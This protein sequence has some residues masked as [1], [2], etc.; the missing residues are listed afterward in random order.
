MDSQELEHLPGLTAQE[1]QINLKKFGYNDL[2]A[3]KKRSVFFLWINVLKEPMFLL[4][5]AS[6][7]IYW[8]IGDIL[9]ASVLFGSIFFI[10]GLTFYQENKTEKTLLALKELSSPKATVIR[11]HTIV[12]IPSREV[13]VGDIIVLKEGDRV[14]ADAQFISGTNITVDESLL[15][16]ES[17]PVNKEKDSSFYSG[18]LVVRGQGI[19]KVTNI[20]TESKIGKIG[21]S[22]QKIKIQKTTL[23]KN[24]GVLVKYLSLTAM[25]TCLIVVLINGI[26][27]SN[28]VDGILSGI[29]LSMSLIPEEIPV[30]LTIFL[31]LGA[32]K[33][34]RSN[35]LTRK[36]SVIENLGSV[37]ALCVDKTGTI[38]KNQMDLSQISVRGSRTSLGDI[39]NLPEQFHELLE[40][41]YLAGSRNPFDPMEKAIK[42]NIYKFLANSNFIHES[43]MLIKEYPI[44]SEVAA[45]SHVWKVTEN[46][47]YV[48]AT[49]G[50]PE[51][52]AKMCNMP[53][54]ETKKLHEEISVMAEEGLRV[55]AVAKA[56][57]PAGSIPNE[58]KALKLTYIGLIGFIDPVRENIG[59]AV[60]ECSKAGVRVIMITGDYAGTAKN[61]ARVI[62]LTNCDE[63]LTGQDVDRLTMDSLQHKLKTVN[64]FARIT[65]EQK[66]HIVNALKSNGEV[67]AMTGDGINDAPA[68]KSAD[69]GIS[70]GLRGTDVAR[71]ASSLVLLDDNF[72]SI[73]NG[74]R[75]GRSIYANIKKAVAFVFSIH[76]PI[77]GL[78]ILPL[79]TGLPKIFYP[80]HI[81]FLELI[82]DPL[83]TIGFQAEKEDKNIMNIPPRNILAKV[84]SKKEM[85]RALLKGF[86]ILICSFSMYIYLVPHF[87]E[88]FARTFTFVSMIFGDFG[89]VFFGRIKHFLENKAFLIIFSL[90]ISVL[91]LAISIPQVRDLFNFGY[92][93]PLQFI[94]AAIAG[95]LSTLYVYLM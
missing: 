3:D 87:G 85:I 66:L 47:H 82:I 6:S 65:P 45:I 7:G 62:G 94:I 89:L 79:L 16:G 73:V 42:T 95:L 20:G 53:E 1:V 27:Y 56:S 4:L 41:A 30:V 23:E 59:E 76:V 58:H 26:F 92:I 90:A 75:S 19:A 71:E 17:V 61:V 74:I 2:P 5:L 40:Y 38:T 32:W 33:M 44:S 12:K 72:I 22:I 51:V 64:V 21:K 93:S 48:V 35:A 86:G 50:A 28:W 70:M 67:V 54:L 68:I 46:Q 15:T 10:I 52:I 18:T 60:I 37:T 9:E 78:A 34:T 24:T 57:I 49:K 88:Q 77:A 11:D 13:A 36:M 91:L 55:L 14:P 31:A 8:F 43:W 80:V 83:C 69:V 25:L 29:T 81:L 84:I 63:V 39:Q